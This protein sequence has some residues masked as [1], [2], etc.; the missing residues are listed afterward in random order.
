MAPEH[1]DS[2]EELL[3]PDDPEVKAETPPAA[4]KPAEPE[5]VDPPTAEEKQ[6]E[7]PAEKP[8][9]APVA[10]STAPA[11]APAGKRSPWAIVTVIILVLLAAAVGLGWYASELRTQLSAAKEE[12]ETVKT[13]A[14]GMQATAGNVADDLAPVI[15]EHAT[16]AKLRAAAGDV[17]GAKYSLLV[18]RRYA[19]M[20]ERLSAGSPSSKLRELTALIEETEK[21]TAGTGDRGGD[22]GTAAAGTAAE[23]PS[24][25]APEAAPAAPSPSATAPAPGAEAAPAATPE[26]AAPTAPAPTP[27]SAAAPAGTGG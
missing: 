10:K 24:A 8:K 2:L 17:E 7:P 23:E 4:A 9:P 27:E 12:L 11:P 21:A 20:A 3:G 1:D 13:Q 15:E 14:T 5:K 6:P 16:V 25:A 22:G 18:A 19:E 26:A